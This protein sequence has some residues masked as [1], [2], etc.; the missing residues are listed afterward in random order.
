MSIESLMENLVDIKIGDLV[1]KRA[2]SNW[3]PDIY[4]KIEFLISE[5]DPAHADIM[6]SIFRNTGIAANRKEF[7]NLY[8]PEAITEM[9]TV[10]DTDFMLEGI[11]EDAYDVYKIFSAVLWN[12]A[13]IANNNKKSMNFIKRSTSND[14]WYKF[15]N[16]FDEDFDNEN[17]DELA[18]FKTKN[19]IRMRRASDRLSAI[20]RGEIEVSPNIATVKIVGVDGYREEKWELNNTK[21]IEMFEDVNENGIVHMVEIYIDGEK[22]TKTCPPNTW[23][24]IKNKMDKIEQQGKRAIHESNNA[25]TKLD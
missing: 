14:L 22:R 16:T 15:L 24:E 5:L 6:K 8:C 21:L 10:I 25:F 19:N 7:W 23:N 11:P 17:F 3:N 18:F 2:K 20:G 12:F 13:Y 1:L 9:C 4:S